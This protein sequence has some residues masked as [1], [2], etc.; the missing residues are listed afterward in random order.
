MTYIADTHA[1]LN[2]EKFPDA[3]VAL[4]NAAAA[5]VEYVVVPGWD[6][7]SSEKAVELAGKHERVYAAVGFIRTMPLQRIVPRLKES[8]TS[9]RIKRWS[10][11]GKSDSIIITTCRRRKS[12]RK[13]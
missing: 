8:P 6:L 1:H 10:P 13:S 9:H 7:P 2:H 12:R 4:A 3:E 5:G 11:S